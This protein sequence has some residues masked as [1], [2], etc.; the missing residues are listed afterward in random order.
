MSCKVLIVKNLVSHQ[1][2]TVEKFRSLEALNIG[3]HQ[4]QSLKDALKDFQWLI[5]I[6]QSLPE[7]S[8]EKKKLHYLIILFNHIHMKVYL[9]VLLISLFV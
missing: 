3:E 6:L 7:V 2:S 8:D 1:I 4:D 5:D 9:T